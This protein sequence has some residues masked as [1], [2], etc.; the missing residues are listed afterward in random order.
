MDGTKQGPLLHIPKIRKV[1]VEVEGP[2]VLL[3]VDE[4]LVADFPWN[5]AVEIGKGILMGARKAEEYAKANQIITD[6]ALL[7]RSGIK[8]GLTSNRSMLREA[9]KEAENSE[10]L[11][12]AIPSSEKGIPSEE[13]IG[14]PMLIQKPPAQTLRPKG[15]G[16]EEKVGTPG[17]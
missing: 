2:R 10:E 8:L 17:K 15:I 3:L 1:S 4:K 12:K 13:I 14:V 7:M 9:Q 5:A 6:Q 11:R 16:S